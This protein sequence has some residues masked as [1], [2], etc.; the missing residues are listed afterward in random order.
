MDIISEIRTFVENE[1]KKPSSKYGY[2]PFPFH[3]VPMVNYA[4]KLADELGGDKELIMVAAWLHDIGSIISGREDHHITG[5]K[6]AEEKLKEFQYPAEKIEL[7]KKCI[8]NHRGSQ[9]NTRDS[10]E[11]QIIAEAD[12]M[13]NFDNISGIFKAAFVYEDK[14]QSEAKE[15]VRLKLKRKW[16]QLHFDN[17]KNIVK[18]KYE[19]AMLLLE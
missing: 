11:E 19:A 12:V 4:K 10:I 18:P 14:T 2:E 5:A 9:Q 13:S 17:S 3:F 1:C 7:V 6:I 16:K 8:L 15:S